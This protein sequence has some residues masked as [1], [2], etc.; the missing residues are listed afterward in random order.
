LA[1]A[2]IAVAASP[3]A[4]LLGCFAIV[5]VVG[6]AAIICRKNA[7]EFLLYRLTHVQHLPESASTRSDVVYLLGGTPD[8]L[9]A[10]FRTASRLIHE[11]KAARVLVMSERSLLPFR[12]DLGRNPTVDE[13]V[14]EK[15]GALG[16]EA[17][18][19]EFVAIE[20][21]FFGTWSEAKSVSHFLRGRGFVRLI[22]VTSP[23]HSRRAWES[24]SRTVEQPHENLFV[25]LSDE[26]AYL[27]H[28]LTEYVKLILYRALLF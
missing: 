11:G 28:L 20:D 1:R 15:L 14:M 3:V 22:L 7:A 27:R 6:V 9:E 21:Q 19:I 25:Y 24:F 2:R 10:K 4:Y 12:P 26:P 5:A 18:T 17:D 8:S 23:L 13:W 16:V